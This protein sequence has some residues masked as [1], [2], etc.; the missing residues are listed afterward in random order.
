MISTI[1]EAGYLRCGISR[2]FLF[3]DM[4]VLDFKEKERERR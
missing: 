4:L 3:V 1:F 2:P